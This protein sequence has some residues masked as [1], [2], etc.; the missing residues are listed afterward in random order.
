MFTAAKVEAADYGASGPEWLDDD[1][2]EIHLNKM[3]CT[4]SEW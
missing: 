1:T 4:I 3:Y 2:T